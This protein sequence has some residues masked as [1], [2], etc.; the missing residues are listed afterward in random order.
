MDA[1]SIRVLIVDDEAIACRRLARLLSSDPEIEI[2]GIFRSA[3]QALV[4]IEQ[5]AIDLIFLDI[6]MS[7]MD[8][9]AL[10]RLL[11][12]DR[13]PTVIFVTA[14]EEHAIRAF[15]VHAIDYLLKP[16]DRERLERALSRAKSEIREGQKRTDYERVLAFVKS[17]NDRTPYMQRLMVRRD[18]RLYL[19][20]TEQVDWFEAVGRHV[21]VHVKDDEYV[22]RESISELQ[23]RLDPGKFVRNHRSSIINLE[24]IRELRPWTHGEFKV[25]LCD[26]T[27]L[28][29]TRTQSKK[30][31]GFLES[32]ASK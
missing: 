23:T 20:R 6:Q 30:F 17:C 18:R 10:L 19:F 1:L 24:R 11:P 3:E 7:E 25:Y 21:R 4:S 26:G 9:F 13:M 8:G 5:E 22:L 15:E 31:R 12:A 27:E 14:Y 28:R 16:F 29:L 2:T 32:T